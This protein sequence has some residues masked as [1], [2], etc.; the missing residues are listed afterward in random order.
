MN[1]PNQSCKRCNGK[2]MIGRNRSTGLIIPCHCMKA[3]TG[4]MSD[5]RVLERKLSSF[6]AQ[7][8]RATR[9]VKF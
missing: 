9:K 1:E 5:L 7:Q 3:D 4:N 8:R 6:N 2:G